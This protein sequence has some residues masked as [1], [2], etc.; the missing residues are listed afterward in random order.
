MANPSQDPDPQPLSTLSMTPLAGAVLSLPAVWIVALPAPLHAVS[1][2][3]TG[4][5][6]GPIDVEPVIHTLGID[7]DGTVSWNDEILSSRAALDARLQA[8]A[9][10]AM[11]HQVEVRV[12][13]HKRAD[14]GTV[15]AVLASAQRH[16]VRQLGLIGEDFAVLPARLGSSI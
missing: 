14:F 7:F 5:C 1:L 9:A 10:A 4:H 12:Q 8:V 11:S 2:D 3:I 16:G 6:G 13:P 15:T